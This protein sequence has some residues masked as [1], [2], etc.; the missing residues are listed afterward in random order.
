MSTLLTKLHQVVPCLVMTKGRKGETEK[1]RKKQ[2]SGG[3]DVRRFALSSAGIVSF[4]SPKGCR[5][6]HALPAALSV[7]V[8][9]P[10]SNRCRIDIRVL[11]FEFEFI[12]LTTHLT[13]TS[14]LTPL[15]LASSHLLLLLPALL[16]IL[17]RW[18]DCL[19]LWIRWHDTCWTVTTRSDSRNVLTLTP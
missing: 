17:L 1:K 9:S 3:E 4:H 14:R 11:H 8:S 13:P 12:S 19:F 18:L 6:S 10:H 7:A 5:T 15:L 2:T 16:R